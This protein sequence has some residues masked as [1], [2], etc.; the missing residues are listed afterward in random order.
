MNRLRLAC[1]LLI[2]IFHMAWF[3]PTVGLAAE[4]ICEPPEPYIAP[5][6]IPS[7]SIQPKS[8]VQLTDN[9]DGTISDF[10]SGLMWAKADSHSA[11]KRCLNYYETREY[12]KNLRTGGY[13]D[14]KIPTIEQ[15]ATIYDPTKESVISWD[16]S[17]DYPLAL[18]EK[19]SDGAAYWYWSAD[20]GETELNKCCARSFYFVNG[21]VNLRHFDQCDNGGVRAVRNIKN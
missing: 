15:L 19:F 18:D 6:Y 8:D 11:L 20:C 3:F 9:N 2:G 4:A 14:W 12:V 1:S 5:P 21:L 16:H 13:D 17:P 7:L 10:N